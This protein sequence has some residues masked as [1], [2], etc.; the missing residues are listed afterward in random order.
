M[1]PPTGDTRR[2]PLLT[3]L[4]EAAA[5]ALVGRRENPLR[6]LP[7]DRAARIRAAQVASVVRLTPLSMAVNL[8]NTGLVVHLFWADGPSRWL[9]G[10]WFALV[11][12]LA[13]AAL[14]NWRAAKR[15]PPRTAV[16]PRATAHTLAHAILFAGAWAALPAALFPMAGPFER[17]ALGCFATGMIAGGAFALS[18][19][20]RAGLAYTWIM[21]LLMGAG[22]A[23]SGDHRMAAAAGFLCFYAAIISRNL[24]AHGDLFAANL[25]GRSEIEAQREVL[26][27]LLRDFEESAGDCLWETDAAGRLRRCPPRFARML[28]VAPETAADAILP[29]LLGRDGGAADRFAARD[30]FRDLLATVPAAGGGERALSFT[31]KPVL[32]ASGAFAGF[33]GVASDVTERV[34]AE[35]ELARTK[36]FLDAVVENVPAVLFAKDMEDGGRYVLLNR[37]GER[38][39]GCPRAAV[40][41]K[42]DRDLFAPDEAERF[43]ANDRLALAATAAAEGDARCVSEEAALAS[44][45]NGVRHLRTR[46]L[47]LADLTAGGTGAGPARYV[48]GI[49]EDVTERK[50][51]EE[52]L[53]EQHRRLDA[54]L[55]HMSHGL[56]MFDAERRLVVCNRRLLEMYGLPDGLGA[57]GTPLRAL[58]EASIARGNHPNLSAEFIIADYEAR[59]SGSEP[60]T[61]F[62]RLGDGRSIEMSYQPLAGGGAV[63]TFEDVSERR[64]AEA[65][66]KEQNERLRLRE[67]ELA[68]QN[69]RFHT[70]IENINQGLCFFDGDHRL[71]VGNRRYAELYGLAPDQ[72]APGTTV[73]EIV[74]RRIAAGT[75]PKG[76]TLE[77]YVVWRDAV[78]RSPGASTNLIELADGR[79]FEVRREATPDGGSVATHQDVTERL[80][81]EAALMAQNERFDAALTNMSQGLAMFDADARLVVHNERV[82]ELF[83]LPPGALRPGQTHREIVE[84]LA[85][86]GLYAAGPSPDEICGS[87]RAPLE[88]DAAS[89]VQ[90]RALANGRTLAIAT[91]PMRTGGYVATYEDVTERRQAEARIMHMARHDALTG[92]S[93]RLSF[94]ERLERALRPLRRGPEGGTNAGTGRTRTAGGKGCIAVLYL[95]LDRFKGV[96]DTLGH[97]AGDALLKAVAGRI[98]AATRAPHGGAGRAEAAIARLGGDEFAVAVAVGAGPAAARAAAAALAARL[99]AVLDEPFEV[100]GHQVVAGTSVGIA[101]APVDGDCPDRL[102]KAAD[103]ALY[104]AKAEGRGTFRFFEPEMDRQARAQ[105]A[106]ET[107]LRRALAAGE[108]ELHY[109]PILDLRADRVSGFEAL[110]RWNH[111]DRGRV[112]PAEFVPVA[113]EIGLMAP[114]GDWVLRTACAEAAA[115]PGALKVAV[116]LSPAQFRSRKL[117]TSVAEAL[118]AS[119]LPP[120]RLELEITETVLLERSEPNLDQLHQLRALGARIAMDDFGTGYSSLGYLRAFP[121]DKIK[122]DRSFVH[123]LEKDGDGGCAAIVR[124]VAGLGAS[125]GVRTTAEGV[126]TAAQL[127]FIRA[128]GCTEVQ[129][130]HLSPPRPAA[131]I[132]AMLR[133]LVHG[134]GKAAADAL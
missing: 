22:M 12:L 48:L 87:F 16:S 94:H 18:A 78:A 118:S 36:A 97:P 92:L 42:T 125:L 43:A 7:E 14:W 79:L 88:G 89:A 52:R 103:L 110:L 98:A 86:L 11:A 33:R 100:E 70:A 20:P 31:A 96:N 34:K 24:V 32:D 108:F 126:E 120:D 6:G 123:D 119:G 47:A 121:F 60:G 107:D 37:A 76:I 111:P 104:K 57:C 23:F 10:A 130:Y 95:D 62:A 30:P 129:G 133:P 25:R 114:I 35:A 1:T 51:D 85:A 21:C 3:A 134:A 127:A 82:L 128:E 71:I 67:E 64:R 77:E 13:G 106:L 65:L 116:N 54:A 105:R 90:Y 19:V 2:R 29:D 91:R 55:T 58:V 80:R 8:L 27:L 113:E 122:I 59:L 115:W 46:K 66:I 73:R 68:V 28:G 131:E 83:G 61:A 117:V 50:R 75:G 26:G 41:G 109:Q 69:A 39:L 38:L 63:V 84:R 17:F 132:A 49:S 9:L 124:A 44:R 56:A 4:A 40:L 102:L 93:N 45:H 74:E 15:R 5:L 72:T 101:L 81:T 112:S 99:V 53:R